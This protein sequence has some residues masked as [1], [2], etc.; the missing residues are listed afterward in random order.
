MKFKPI[1][2]EEVDAVLRRHGKDWAAIAEWV[3]KRLF[4]PAEESPNE[5]SETSEEKGKK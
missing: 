2:E 5:E 3:S 4:E 1:T